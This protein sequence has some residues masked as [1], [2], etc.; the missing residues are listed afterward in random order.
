[1]TYVNTTCSRPDDDGDGLRYNKQG[2]EINPNKDLQGIEFQTSV[3]STGH[4][5]WYLHEKSTNNLL[6]SGNTNTDAGQVIQVSETLTS[7]TAYVISLHD[8]SAGDWVAGI[9]SGSGSDSPV[10][11]EYL[12]IISGVYW[13]SSNNQWTRSAIYPAVNDFVADIDASA[14]STPQNLTSTVSQDDITLDWDAVNWNGDQSHYNIKRAESTGGA[15]TEVDTVAAGTTTY[16]DSALED[17]EQFFYVVE[18]ENGVGSS[19]NSNETNETTYLPAP[20]NV[21]ATTI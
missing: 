5:E 18:A 12:D 11:C 6:A 20:S 17:G 14:P 13:S 8:P 1:M 16:T 3:N 2:I 21:D 4:D 7:G 10:S 19:G 9:Y 15:Y